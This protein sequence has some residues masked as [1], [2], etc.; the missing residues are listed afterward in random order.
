MLESILDLFDQKDKA[1]TVSF[2]KKPTE[3]IFKKPKSMRKLNKKDIS[4]PCNF[5]HVSGKSNLSLVS[6]SYI[7]IIS[8]LSIY[9]THQHCTHC[10]CVH[11]IT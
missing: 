11:I 10:I 5:K 7:C 4:T 8:K 9:S 1:E 2:D 6:S 3:P